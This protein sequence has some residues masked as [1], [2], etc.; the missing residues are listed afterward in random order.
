MTT[1][2]PQDR[3]PARAIM[4]VTDAHADRG[5]QHPPAELVIAG[6]VLAAAAGIVGGAAIFAAGGLYALLSTCAG[7]DGQQSG[8][9]ENFGSLVESLEWIAV[10]GGGAAAIAGGVG[11]AATG[12]ARWIAGGFGIAL[13]L[14]ALL[15]VLVG[16]QEG[17]LR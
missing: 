13:L 12:R 8:L 16:A 7:L 5:R 1:D 4:D 9:C 11:T 17:G 14:V 3:F 15:V 10:L 2:A 6:R